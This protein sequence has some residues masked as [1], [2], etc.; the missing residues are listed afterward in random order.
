MKI[1]SVDRK[2][3]RN[4]FKRH[5]IETT[6]IRLDFADIF[7][8]E[9]FSSKAISKIGKLFTERRIEKG[10]NY[11]ISNEGIFFEGEA[12]SWILLDPETKNY[13]KISNTFFVIEY[14]KYSSFEEFIETFKKVFSIYK[15]LFKDNELKRIGLRKINGYSEKENKKI[16]SF[17]G[18]FN[19]FLIS[20]LNSSIFETP[21]DLDEDRHT[22]STK[23]KGYKVTLNYGTSRGTQNG[24]NARKFF[25]DI[26]CFTKK[27]INSQTLLKHIDKMNNC[28]FDVFYWSISGK[29]IK[30]LSK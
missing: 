15:S 6:I 23:N 27:D 21:D 13:V 26:D 11:K 16:S 28:L 1:D 2:S 7:T 19:D 22:I 8:A 25:L 10:R 14:K 24:D 18:Y 9:E 5:L 3:I 17:K 4:E 30:K 29:M 20:H 12:K